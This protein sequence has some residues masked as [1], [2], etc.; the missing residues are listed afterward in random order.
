MSWRYPVA[1]QHLLAYPTVCVVG[2]ETRGVGRGHRGVSPGG[3]GSAGTLL[4]DCSPLVGA[5]RCGRAGA[6]PLSFLLQNPPVGVQVSR[7]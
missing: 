6:H 1:R 2:E 3:V 5:L 4:A 7:W